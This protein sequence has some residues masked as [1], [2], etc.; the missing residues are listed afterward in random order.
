MSPDQ[1]RAALVQLGYPDSIQLGK[2][3]G[4]RGSMAVVA[5]IAA[6]LG[7]SPRQVYRY[8]SGGTPVPLYV[9]KHVGTLLENE[10]LRQAC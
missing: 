8:L 7:I 4:N 5:R 9:E 2:G 6:R 3:G 10:R 1:F